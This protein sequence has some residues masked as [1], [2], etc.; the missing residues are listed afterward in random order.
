MNIIIIGA[1]IHGCCIAQELLERGHTVTIIEK[2]NDILQG[3][4]SATHNRI[5]LGYH[6][7][8]SIETAIE[9]RNSYDVF[10]DK[11][12]DC[13]EFPEFYYFI[14][15]ENSHID[16]KQYEDFL[17]NM[18]LKIDNSWPKDN[19]LVKDKIEQSYLTSEGCFNLEKI[20]E[21]LRKNVLNHPQCTVHFDFELT[22]VSNYNSLKL[23]SSK[24]S[25]LHYK[26]VL[27]THDAIINCTYTYSQNIQKLFGISWDGIYIYEETEIVVVKSD[28]KIPPLTIMDGPF[29]TI[30]PY[31]GHPGE[32]LIYDVVNSRL[33]TIEDSHYKKQICKSNHEKILENCKNYFE[34]MNNIEYVKSLYASRPIPKTAINDS[35]ITRIKKH[36]NT[37]N[38]L[39]LYSIVEGKFATAPYIAKKFV[40]TLEN[41][42]I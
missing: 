31:I 4:S 22:T 15:K 33:N 14:A 30:L 21:K 20:K 3:T 36:K 6:Y 1:G 9:C 12:N 27:Y 13:L 25:I 35:R 26:D 17:N 5:H 24:N 29:I 19:L 39:P 42:K 38:T 11:F 2:N 16:A 34:F 28:L 40:E 7:P 18:N 8:R 41:N 10:L 37:K 23:T 32:Y